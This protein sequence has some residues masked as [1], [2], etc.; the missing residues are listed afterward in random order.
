MTITQ[1]IE[2]QYW[3]MGEVADILGVAESCVRYWDKEFEIV[4]KRSQ[5]NH[6]RFTLNEITKFKVV[7]FLLHTEKYTVEGSKSKLKLLKWP[8][9]ANR[10]EEVVR[11]QLARIV[12]PNVGL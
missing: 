10:W 5:A 6:R 11:V 12:A 8:M 3:T 1:D 4:H 2:K 7:Q 9:P